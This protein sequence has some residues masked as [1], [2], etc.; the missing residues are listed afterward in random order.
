MAR[1]SVILVLLF[2]TASAQ[3]SYS[4]FGEGFSLGENQD[5]IVV[6]Y[7]AH[8]T[9]LL[10]AF[11][12]RGALIDR[13]E[14]SPMEI[15]IR[16]GNKLDLSQIRVTAFNSRD[17]IVEGVPLT[18][19]LEGPE[20]LLDF[21]DFRID[22]STVTAVKPGAAIIWVESLAPSRSGEV[23]RESIDLIVE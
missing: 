18:F 15:R 4:R 11:I 13:L 20:N 22:G 14:V 3:D 5:A 12:G 1:F 10:M 2:G 21:E 23:I 9:T 16:V 17:R 8:T 6:G 19:H 7:R